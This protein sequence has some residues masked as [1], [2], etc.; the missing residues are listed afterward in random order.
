LKTIRNNIKHEIIIKN[1][2]FIALLYYVQTEAEINQLLKSTKDE[3]KNATHYCYAYIINEIKRSNDDG[4]PG[5]TAGTPILN[6]LEKNGLTNIICIVIRYFGG[7]KLGVGGLIRA[8]GQSVRDALKEA[9]SLDIVKC[10][11][12][13]FT[14]NYDNIKKIDSVINGIAVIS[15]DFKDDIKYTIRLKENDFDIIE[16][17]KLFSADILEV[18]EGY[19]FE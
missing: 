18:K 16:K 2:K 12:V 3:Y 1:S 13:T 17:L 11:D 4:E 15:K 8:Y 5:G 7:T 19:S 9:S 6:V 10:Y 14:F